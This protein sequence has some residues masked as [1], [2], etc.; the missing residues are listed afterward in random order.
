MKKLVIIGAGGFGREVAWQVLE[1]KS[2]CAQYQLIGFV[3]DNDNLVGTCFNGLP[4]LGTIDWLME[5]EEPMAVMAAV[6]SAKIRKKI[7]D[8]CKK[9]KNLCFPTF[10]AN[11]AALSDTVKIGEGGI[12]CRGNILTVNITIG[13]FALINLSCTIGHDVVMED[14]V[15]LYPGVHVSGNVSIGKITEIGTGTNIIQGKAIGSHVTI[16]AGSVIIRDIE[17][18]CTA[19]GV[20]ARRVKHE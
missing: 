1:Q 20:P 19:V 15:T 9:N 14:Y 3:D 16:G 2:F 12:I 18:N 11:D 17:D 5:Q 7:V 8:R 13:A 4:V 10:I 6:G